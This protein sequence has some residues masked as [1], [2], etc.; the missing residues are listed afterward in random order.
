MATVFLR[1]IVREN[2]LTNRQTPK[3]HKHTGWKHYHV[4]ITGDEYTSLQAF[5]S[6]KQT[7]THTI[8]NFK[9]S[10]VIVPEWDSVPL[11]LESIN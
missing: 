10:Q 5:N 3:K 7:C 1:E 9:Q 11:Q 6:H 8:M 2:L 4:A